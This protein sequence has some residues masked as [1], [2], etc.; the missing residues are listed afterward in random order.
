MSQAI[1]S[2]GAARPATSTQSPPRKVVKAIG[3]KLRR[4][5]YLL[6]VLL[7]ILFANSAYLATITFL[8]WFKDQTYQNYFY[9]LM[10]LAHLFL[11]LL[12]IIP[13]LVF[14]FVHIANTRYRR[15]RRAVKVGYLLFAISLVLLITGLLL[16]RVGG[17]EIKNPQPVQ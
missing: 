4:V 5:L 1:P 12:V 3:P 9:Q 8:E 16:F 7:A 15:N 13:F 14:S 17:F 10:F 11:G 6:L 2:D